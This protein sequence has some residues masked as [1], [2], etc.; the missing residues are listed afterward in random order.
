MAVVASSSVNGG[1]VV[2]VKGTSWNPDFMMSMCCSRHKRK[3][4]KLFD[5]IA[6]LITGHAPVVSTREYFPVSRNQ[7]K[8]LFL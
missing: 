1:G 5:L 3:T 6:A 8:M 7:L 2:S 4:W